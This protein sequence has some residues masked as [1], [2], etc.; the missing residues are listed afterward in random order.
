M[1]NF[2]AP[3]G[4]SRHLGVVVEQTSGGI[5]GDYATFKVNVPNDFRNPRHKE[6]TGSTANNRTY[7][8]W[9]VFQS[10]D[11]TQNLTIRR[12]ALKTDQMMFVEIPLRQLIQT[13][14][15]EKKVESTPRFDFVSIA[16]SY[17]L[18][19]PPT[20]VKPHR[21]NA[22][23]PL[24]AFLRAQTNLNPCDHSLRKIGND[25]N[26]DTTVHTVWLAHPADDQPLGSIRGAFGRNHYSRISSTN[27]LWT[28]MPA[29]DSRVL[30]ARAVRP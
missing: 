13:L 1:S 17:P 10:S 18:D 25:L 12:P 30:R 3:T 7:L 15:G 2:T 27:R 14:F 4:Q 11:R 29:A 28:F 9:I 6:V 26:Q 21:V 8:T 19:Q 24:G 23:G 16:D 20:A 22:D 5:E